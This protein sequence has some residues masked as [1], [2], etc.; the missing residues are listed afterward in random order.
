MNVPTVAALLAL[1][2]SVAALP[3]LGPHYANM[4]LTNDSGETFC[5]VKNQEGQGK[6]FVFCI[7]GKQASF[8]EK[9]NLVKGAAF[10]KAMPNEDFQITVVVAPSNAHKDDLNVRRL[11]LRVKRI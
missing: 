9:G 7:T 3:Q 2:F 4:D 5:P 11:Y 6:A 1:T 10:I 8:D